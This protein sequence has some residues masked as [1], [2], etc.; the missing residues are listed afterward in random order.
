MKYGYW[1]IC[2]FDMFLDTSY[3]LVE[4]MELHDKIKV[5]INMSLIKLVFEIELPNAI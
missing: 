4:K 2:R 3:G 5:K 1:N